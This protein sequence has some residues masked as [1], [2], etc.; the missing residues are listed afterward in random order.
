MI[1]DT[2]GT[3]K[4]SGPSIFP[5]FEGIGKQDKNKLPL[6]LPLPQT[7]GNL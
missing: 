6:P 2:E 3:T 5:E 1:L 4:C 7:G